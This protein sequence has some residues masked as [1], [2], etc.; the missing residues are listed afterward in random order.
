MELLRAN[1]LRTLVPIVVGAVVT[2]LPGTL[3]SNEQLP[4]LVGFGVSYVYYAVFRVAET[5][6][7]R[8]GLFLGKTMPS[9]RS[10]TAAA[11]PVTGQVVAGQGL[12][13]RVG[14]VR[15]PAVESVAWHQRPGGTPLL[16]VAMAVADG[17][18]VVGGPA[19]ALSDRTGPAARAAGSAPPG[20]GR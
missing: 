9:H 7:P 18:V 14:G 6:Y 13:V 15:L 12:D 10:P 19:A 4:V 16:R 20:P 3:G 8:L 1:L 17:S 11:P 2:V 5:R